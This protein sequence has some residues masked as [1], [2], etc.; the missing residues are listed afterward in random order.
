MLIEEIMIK[1]V[2]T[3]SPEHTAKDALQVMQGKKIRHLP[4]VDSNGTVVGIITDRDLKEAIP[5]LSR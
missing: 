1:D 5:Q 4:I 3:L 2:I